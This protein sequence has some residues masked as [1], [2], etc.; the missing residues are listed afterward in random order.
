MDVMEW[1]DK[2]VPILLPLGG[3][4]SKLEDPEEWQDWATNVIM[5][6]SKWQSTTPSPYQF[7]D[8]QDWAER[9]LSSTN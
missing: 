6:N 9:F 3:I 7:D 2:M 5:L 1:A 8:W 4:V